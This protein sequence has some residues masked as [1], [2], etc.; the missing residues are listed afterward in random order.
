MSFPGWCL[1]IPGMRKPR[2]RDQVIK[3][4]HVAFLVFVNQ[5]ISKFMCVNHLLPQYRNEWALIPDELSVAVEVRG[6]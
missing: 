5:N 4:D 3:Q 2:E 6:S 1:C